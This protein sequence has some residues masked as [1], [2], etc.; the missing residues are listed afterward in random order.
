MKDVPT[1]VALERVNSYNWDELPENVYSLP[2]LEAPSGDFFANNRVMA[3]YIRELYEINPSSHFNFYCVDNYPELI[4]QFFVAQGIEN[5]DATLVSDG[6]SSAACFQRMT[7]PE[8]QNGA[9]ADEVYGKLAAEWQRI[10]AAA[11]AGDPN[12]LENVF[13]GNPAKVQVLENYA[14]V[15]ATLEENVDW[16]VARKSLFTDNANSAY[17]LDLLEGTNSSGKNASGAKTNIYYPSF[18]T[19]FNKLSEEDAASL[20]RLYKFDSDAFSSAGDKEV[21]M[22]LGTSTANEGDLENYLT[23]LQKTYG[24]THKIFYKGHPGWP[25]AL[26]AEKQAM[27]NRLGVVDIESYIAAEIILFYCPDIYLVGYDTSTF[28]SAQEGRILTVFITE[29]AGK[30]KTYSS[31]TYMNPVASY[32]NTYEAYEGCYVVEYADSARVD[33]YDPVAKTVTTVVPAE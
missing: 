4:L 15:I 12:Y 26:N 18:G 2:A 19:M 14:F 25:T 5:F 23:Y 13:M 9:T 24:D 30:D 33:I 3:A 21:L 31:N 28:Y 1:F 10:K 17:I 8:A 29:E 11:A 27:L 32:G 16:W 6:T 7:K 22:V 20:K